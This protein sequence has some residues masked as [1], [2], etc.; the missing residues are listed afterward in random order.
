[1]QSRIQQ[2]P[3]EK[4]C[5]LLLDKVSRSFALAIR[6]LPKNVNTQIMAAYLVYRV[7]D[8]IEDSGADYKVKKKMFR[9]VID[10]ISL[11]HY[12]DIRIAQTMEY[13]ERLISP[14]C[15]REEKELL[16]SYKEVAVVFYALPRD[17]RRSI[18]RWGKVMVKGMEKFLRKKIDT[19]RDQ[20]IYSYYV[21][22]VVGYLINDV[23]YYNRIIDNQLRKQ[24]KRSA[25]N[26]GL[27]LQKINI[28]R[29]IA[30]DV[31]E[32]RYYWPLSFLRKHSVSYDK[33]CDPK[34]RKQSL[35]I[36]NMLVLDS[37]KY[38]DFAIKYVVSLP[39]KAVRV[40]VFCLIP[41]VMAIETYVKCINNSDVFDIHKK[42]K[43]SRM[44]VYEILAF[45][46]IYS[47]FNSLLIRW[48]N[49]TMLKVERALRENGIKSG[50]TYKV[51]KGM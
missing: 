33:L 17:I 6:M 48:F 18:L 12:D 19:L 28:L 4:K 47:P 41:L 23:L 26:F 24:L 5:W 16:S 20:T 51:A 36:L 42:V 38:I 25:K 1:M 32:E 30:R 50:I 13:L 7:I 45:A 46:W 27:A 34:V 14:Y 37:L 31:V 11:K 8:T 40:R 2:K 15:S 21:A 44:K 49:K 9:E 10:S 35:K 22:G 43:I 39:V 29:D 3:A